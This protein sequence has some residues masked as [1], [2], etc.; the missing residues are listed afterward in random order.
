M[1]TKEPK[2]ST[3]SD[4]P[5]LATWLAERGARRVSRSTHERGRGGVTLEEWNIRGRLVVVRLSWRKTVR[6]T[7]EG[8]GWDVLTAPETVDMAETFA[9]VESRTGGPGSPWSLDARPAP[10]GGE[11]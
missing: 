11:G 6:G 8:G 10:A 2:F 1:G 9:D 5:A 4:F 7:P 3:V